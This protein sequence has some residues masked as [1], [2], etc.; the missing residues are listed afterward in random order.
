M[1]LPEQ[2][3]EHLVH[4]YEL[5]PPSATNVSSVQLGPHPSSGCGAALPRQGRAQ[6]YHCWSGFDG[7]CCEDHHRG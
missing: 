5:A 6:H 2:A 7:S 3:D 4:S 1:E